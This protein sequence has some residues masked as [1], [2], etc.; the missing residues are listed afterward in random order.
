MDVSGILNVTHYP[1]KF[2]F[3]SGEEVSVEPCGVVISAK[4]VE[5][6]MGTLGDITFVN[7][8]FFSN[9][10]GRE[11]LNKLK[12][13][14]PGKVIVGSA[15]AAKAY[16]GEIVSVVPA[17]G[18]ERLAPENRRANP[19]KFTMYSKEEKLA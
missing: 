12:A 5:K 19:M 16:P 18:Y 6:V 7:T 17:K 11:D 3:E 10:T 14:H 8:G 2:L 4:P 9:A 13:K 1:I 15:L